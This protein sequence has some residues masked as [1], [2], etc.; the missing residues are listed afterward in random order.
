[1]FDQIE[2]RDQTAGNQLCY[3]DYRFLDEVCQPEQAFLETEKFPVPSL[4]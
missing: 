4:R 3:V 2:Q 1:L